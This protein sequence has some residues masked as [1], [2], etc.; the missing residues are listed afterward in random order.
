LTESIGELGRDRA[1]ALLLERER[2]RHQRDLDRIVVSL[3]GEQASE[4]FLVGLLQL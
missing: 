4:R 1:L 3:G 2:C